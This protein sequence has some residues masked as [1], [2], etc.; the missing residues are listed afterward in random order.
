VSVHAEDRPHP[1]GRLVYSVEEAADLLGMGR[2]F[3]YHLVATREIDSFKI[4]T[5]R[6]IPREAIDA[7]IAR[8]RADQG[9]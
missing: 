8:L 1:P 9:G 4:G 5:R 2:T 3:M 7:Y 6:K